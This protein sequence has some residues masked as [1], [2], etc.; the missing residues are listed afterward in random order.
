MTATS[1][2]HVGHA[3]LAPCPTTFRQLGDGRLKSSEIK[4]ILGQLVEAGEVE[5]STDGYRQV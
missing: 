4:D 2:G 3:H 5:W 1:T